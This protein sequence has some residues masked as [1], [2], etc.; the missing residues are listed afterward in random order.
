MPDDLE[1]K[2]AASRAAAA[3]DV[4]S[5]VESIRSGLLS[6]STRLNMVADLRRRYHIVVDPWSGAMLGMDDDPSLAIASYNESTMLV[7]DDS[8]PAVVDGV[9]GL[10]P[11]LVPEGRFEA[12]ENATPMRCVVCGHVHDCSGA[13]VA[14]ERDDG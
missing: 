1:L 7:G 8:D 13:A 12:A 6:R 11:D 3:I 2:V 9:V 10:D 14:D 4:A 5:Q